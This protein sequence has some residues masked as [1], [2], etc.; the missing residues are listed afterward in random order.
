MIAFNVT[1]APGTRRLSRALL[2]GMSLTAFAV[3]AGTA[4]AQQ[5]DPTTP[6]EVA[7]EQD[8]VVT[9]LRASFEASMDIKRDSTGVVDAIS[10]QDIGKFPDTNLA[11][12]LQRIPGV[13]IDRRNGEGARVTI[14]GF[15]PQFNLVTV[16]GR[17]IATSDTNTVGG[18]QDVDFSRATSRSFDFSNLASEGVSRLEVYKTGRSALPSG[19]IGA[20]INVVTQRPLDRR[21]SGLTGSIGA[22]ALYDTS[23]DDFKVNPEV[24]GVLSWSDDDDR[25]GVSLFGAYQKRDSAAASSTSNDWNVAR[26]ADMPGRAADTIIENAPSDPNT[27]V[28]IPNDSRYH[29]SESS[30]ERINASATLQFKPVETLTL[31]AD[32][33]YAQNKISEARS[34]QGN[35]FNRPFD[36]VRFDDNPVIATA[37]YLEEGSRYGVK[38]I[39]FEQQ[40]RATKTELESYG[41]NASWEIGEGLTLNLDGNHSKSSSLPDARNGASSTLVSLGAPVVDGHSVDYSGKIPQQ[42]W[43]LNDRTRGNGNGVLDIGDLGTQVQR[44]NSSTQRHRLNQIRG[45]LGW[46]FEGGG[47]FDIGATYI[48]SRMTSARIQTQQ[49]LGDWGITQVGDVQ[50]LAGDLLQPFCMSCKF[51]RYSPTGNDI[52]F[53]GNAVDLYEAFADAYVTAGN[54][55]NVTGRDFDRINEKIWS[56]YAQFTWKGDLMGRPSSL[57]VGAR[58]ENTKTDAYAIIALPDI[59]EWDSDNDFS[60]I[61]TTNSL[62]RTQ[63]GEYS[64][65]LPA[66]DF[67]IEPMD[68]VVARAS[69]SRTLARPD[70]GNLFASQ[71]ANGPNRPTALGGVA[72]GSQGNTNLKPLVSDNFDISLEYYYA[73]SSYVS[74]GFFAKKVKNFVGVGQERLNLFGLR[75][76]TTGAPGTRSGTALTQLQTL[77]IT[78][79][80]VSLFT[81]TALLDENNG[82]LAA[83]TAQL[84]ANINNGVL[85]QAFVDQ[86]LARR[87]VLADGTDPLFEFS[88]STPINNRQGNIH[89]F[90]IQG[91]HFFGET[92]FGVSGSFTKVSG[93]VSVDVGADP[94]QNVFALVGLSDSFN[95][96]GIFEKY[97]ASARVSYNWRDKYLSATNRGGSRNPVFYA[98]FGTLDANLS[99]DITENIAVS[100]EAINILSEPVRTYARD[101]KQ[102]YFAQELKPRILVGARY[103]F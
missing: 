31:T 38:D 52:A 14:R 7:D 11:E 98:P 40:Y 90:E 75:D 2:L 39:G 72:T 17:Q 93:D 15:G 10:A 23:N 58:Y 73:R 18:D 91:Q 102:L 92:G 36:R 61:V 69:Y 34:D 88:V 96:T 37:V 63:E 51:D 89:G 28:A 103:R 77:G 6:P 65:L 44:T 8:I 70:Y 59:I 25:F 43:T 55:I 19:G 41:L 32:V 67:Q 74:V 85:D 27:L 54:P 42:N 95:I 45:D 3:S 1:A 50:R 13:S 33:I 56:A 99:Y 68:N 48:D 20:T 12:S 9:G 66:I 64:N 81:L 71:S 86:V 57:V 22:K 78:V 21:D 82:N 100:L 79:S 87:D 16:N 4:H 60:R 24:S 84:Q 47:R 94:T 30:R 26:F 83:A 35:W 53:R 101:T 46:E 5:A 97:G 29:Y 76:P 62:E 80:D 49:T